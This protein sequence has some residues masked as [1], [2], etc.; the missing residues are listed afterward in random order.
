LK[1]VSV[2]VRPAECLGL[3]GRNGAG[4]STL[5]QVI[6]GTLTPSEGEVAVTGR[7]A[8]LLELG[9]G[10]NP[11]FTGRENV[12]VNAAILGLDRERI[13][14]VMPEIQAFA[15]LGDFFDQPVSMYS[16]G[17]YVRLAFAVQTAIDPDV[18]I[19][20]EALSVGDIFFQQKCHARFDRLIENGCSII[21][22][23]HDLRAIRRYCSK[24]LVLQEGRPF[25]L[26]GPSE[27]IARYETLKSRGSAP[28]VAQADDQP[29]HL[30][31]SQKPRTQN[32]LHV[33]QDWPD[34]SCFLSLDQA[35]VAGVSSAVALSG[36]AICDEVG[37]PTNN[38]EIGQTAVFYLEFSVHEPVS[39]PIIALEVLN[40]M[41]L[42]VHSKA[43]NQFENLEP[44]DVLPGMTI[45]LRQTITLEISP[46]EYTIAV[47]VARMNRALFEARETL[48]AATF[49]TGM[50]TLCRINGAGRIVVHERHEGLAQPFY[51]IAGLPGTLEIEVTPSAAM[52]A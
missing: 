43:S 23:S 49:F 34:L 41:N 51:G 14:A 42:V 44:V 6:A 39:V 28:F 21:M 22:V 48:S 8:A 29:R 4:K 32:D 16:S 10:F 3:I 46:G 50:E 24:V 7:V 5:L 11:N 38:F 33:I 2:E 45:R 18:L 47:G 17:M 12:Y 1:D 31:L 15:E 40:R 9:S 52:T 35:D 36:I 13:D 25:F 19:V 37:I 27:A 26:G 30:L 20:D